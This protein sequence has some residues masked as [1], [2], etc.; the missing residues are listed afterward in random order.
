MRA[1]ILILLLLAAGCGHEHSAC[2]VVDYHK[3]SNGDLIVDG[4]RH[5]VD[6]R[7]PNGATYC[8]R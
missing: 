8:T 2:M 4:Q 1:L 7:L 6:H 3:D 5:A